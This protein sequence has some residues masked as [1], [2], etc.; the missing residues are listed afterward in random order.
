MPESGDNLAENGKSNST[1][2]PSTTSPS[3]K[4]PVKTHSGRIITPPTRYDEKVTDSLKACIYLNLCLCN[5][6]I[7]AVYQP[8]L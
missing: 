7:V 5:I 1:V 6:I 4:S 8:Q 3:A 2:P